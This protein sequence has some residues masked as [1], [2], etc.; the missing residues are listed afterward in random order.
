MLIQMKSVY[1]EYGK[2]N[3]V[4]VLKGIDLEVSEGEM[5]AIKGPSGSGKSTLLQLL[6]C[7]DSI[8]SGTYLLDGKDITQMTPNQLAQIRNKIFGF[9]V[10]NFALIESDSVLENVQVPLLFC[11]TKRK[12]AEYLAMERLESVGMD[13]L[14]N[15][16]VAKLSGG[17]KQRVAIARALVNKPG[18]I[19]ADE[20][21]GALDE[22]NTIK[23]MEIFKQLNRE[24]KTIIIVTHED[25]VADQCNRVIT[26]RDGR[27]E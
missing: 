14:Y 24:G 5:L 19:L 18:I 10:Q 25:Y 11:N 26:I 4:K 27:I 3:I 1:K 15:R 23:I 7:L 12:R 22:E 13:S 2:S 21:T 9:V 8:T 6:G 20:P 16:K 17:E